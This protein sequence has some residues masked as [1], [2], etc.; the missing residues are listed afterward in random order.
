V[1]ERFQEK[2]WNPKSVGSGILGKLEEGGM[3]GMCVEWI[4]KR[5]SI[6]TV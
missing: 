1:W 4:G 6:G 3:L 2:L 5:R